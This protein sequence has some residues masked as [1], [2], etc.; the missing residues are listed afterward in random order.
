VRKR[1][2]EEKERGDNERGGGEEGERERMRD[3]KKWWREI[4]SG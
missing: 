1:E 3:L 2:R 4:F